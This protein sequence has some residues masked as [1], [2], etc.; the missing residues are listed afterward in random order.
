[1]S[2]LTRT[3]GT[4]CLDH[5]NCACRLAFVVDIHVYLTVVIFALGFGLGYMDIGCHTCINME[6]SF[7][8]GYED[9]Q[10]FLPYDSTTI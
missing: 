9:I 1:M 6:A 7:S 8:L 3:L 10:V 4:C 2:A 5:I